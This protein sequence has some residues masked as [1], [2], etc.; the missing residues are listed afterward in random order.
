MDFLALKYLPLSSPVILYH[1]SAQS[2]VVQ[3][4]QPKLVW[5][6]SSVCDYNTTKP[7]SFSCVIIVCKSLE[8]RIVEVI[9]CCLANCGTRAENAHEGHSGKELQTS[10][11]AYFSASKVGLG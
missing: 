7:L 10:V 3:Q 8:L 9:K 2:L 6:E 4:N 1:W 11:S 5:L